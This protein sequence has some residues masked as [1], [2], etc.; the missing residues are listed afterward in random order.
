MARGGGRTGSGNRPVDLGHDF[1]G[2]ELHRAARER[3]VDPV[4]AAVEER[5]EVADLLPE[6][7]QLVRDL[8]GRAGDDEL[9]D[10][11]GPS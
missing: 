5:P 11:A 6:G 8:V 9:V 4:D 10:D 3:R 1:L 7:D 2:H